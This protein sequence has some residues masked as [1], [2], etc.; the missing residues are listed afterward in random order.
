MKLKQVD[1]LW[2]EVIAIVERFPSHGTRLLVSI[3]PILLS[4]IKCRHK[5]ILNKFV[6]MWNRTFGSAEALEYPEDL[7]K[8]LFQLRSVIDIQLPTFPVAE[9]DE[10]SSKASQE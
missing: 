2:E 1:E 10:V 6:A 9:V 4:C 8:A 3:Q 7:C 5:S